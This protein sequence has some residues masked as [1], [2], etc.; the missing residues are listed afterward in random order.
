MRRDND[1]SIDW[2][3]DDYADV[4]DELIDEGMTMRSA[5]GET[6]IKKRGQSEDRKE[7]KRYDNH[8]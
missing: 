8:I 7:E 3:T 4:D 1:W 6:Y 5:G 2:L